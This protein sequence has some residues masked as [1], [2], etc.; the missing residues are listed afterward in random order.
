M[1]EENKQQQMLERIG[2]EGKEES[3]CTVGG[4]VN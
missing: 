4:N 1:T 2:R 3:L